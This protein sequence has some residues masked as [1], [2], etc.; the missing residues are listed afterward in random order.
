MERPFSANNS[1]LQLHRVLAILPAYGCHPRLPVD[2]LF[3]LGQG[4]EASSPKGYAEKWAARMREEYKVASDNSRQSSTRGKHY[5]QNV[6][7]VTL[8]PG[9]RVLVRNFGKRGGPGKL[10]SYWENTVHQV[11]EQLNN[12]PVYKV[13]PESGGKIRTLHRNL[14]HLVNDLPAEPVRTKNLPEPPPSLTQ[15]QDRKGMKRG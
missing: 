6:R 15:S 7:G 1:C 5:D 13:C 8:L 4:E 3:R 2:L 11:K 14:L 12:G 10:K 9:D